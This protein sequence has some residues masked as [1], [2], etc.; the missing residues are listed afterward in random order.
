ML[1]KFE[2]VGIAE[3]PK[4]AILDK[5]TGDSFIKQKVHHT[6]FVVID[7]LPQVLSLWVSILEFVVRQLAVPHR[8]CL[9]WGGFHMLGNGARSLAPTDDGH[10]HEA[11][12]MALF[13][14][15]VQRRGMWS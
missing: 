12:N 9:P 4:E 13:A 7:E 3:L 14:D 11:H 8:Q 10:G 6:K 2:R 1:H 15:E 5:V